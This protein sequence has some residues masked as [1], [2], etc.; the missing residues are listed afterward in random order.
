MPRVGNKHFSY[1][2]KG[3]AKAKAHAKKTNQSMTYESVYGKLNSMLSETHQFKKGGGSPRNLPDKEIL[4][5][6]NKL[7]SIHRKKAV[8]GVKKQP[9]LDKAISGHV[10]E[11]LFRKAAKQGTSRPGAAGDKRSPLNR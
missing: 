5:N 11:F 6:M 7:L 3:R 1:S 10:K 4:K 2:K 8:Q 9:A